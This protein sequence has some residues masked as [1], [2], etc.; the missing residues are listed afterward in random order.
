MKNGYNPRASKWIVKDN[1]NT[2]HE[3]TKPTEHFGSSFKSFWEANKENRP[4]KKGI[5]KGWQLLEIVKL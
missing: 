5:Y 3:I 1:T 4:I 2:I